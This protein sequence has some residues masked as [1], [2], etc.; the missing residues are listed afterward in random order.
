M[1]YFERAKRLEEIP[2]LERFYESQREND[3]KF[4]EDQE[5][6]RVSVMYYLLRVAV[7]SNAHR[8]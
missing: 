7:H 5:E 8:L 4:H 6:E 2:L 1:D 3:R